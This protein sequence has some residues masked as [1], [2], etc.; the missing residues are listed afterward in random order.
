[1]LSV[2]PAKAA[3]RPRHDD[4]A[5]PERLVNV[6]VDVDILGEMRLAFGTGPIGAP[7]VSGAEALAALEAAWEGGIRHFD[8]APAYGEAEPRL[9]AALAGHSRSEYTVSTKVGRVSMA[10]SRP[11][12]PGAP[13]DGEARF[14]FSAAGVLASLERS[15]ERLGLTSVD[16]ALIH[17]PDSHVDQALAEALPAIRELGVEV[18]IGTTDVA[19]AFRFVDHVDVVMIAGRWTLAD[20]SGEG[21]LDACAERGVRVLAAAPFNSGLLACEDALYDYREPTGEAVARVAAL[22]ELHGDN[23][24]GAALRFPLSHPAVSHVVA[25]MSSAAEVAANLQAFHTS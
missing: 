12:E 7:S 10:K 22:R 3:P 1:M 14:D 5:S 20:R 17:D 18:G 21:L 4:A 25:G 19:T 8:T 2:G 23:L 16:V 9:G 11:Y 6:Y 15:H 13:V 24:L